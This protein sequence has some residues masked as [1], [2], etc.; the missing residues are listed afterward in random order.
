MKIGISV[1]LYDRG[2]FNDK[3]IVSVL[4][5]CVVTCNVVA[6]GVGTSIVIEPNITPEYDFGTLFASK[7]YTYQFNVYNKGTK[8][9][10][11][12]FRREIKKAKH[13][14]RNKSDAVVEHK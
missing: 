4:H 8:L 10:R 11:V 5:G 9:H 6:H 1:Y 2:K 13:F 7:K 14:M 12:V 3:I